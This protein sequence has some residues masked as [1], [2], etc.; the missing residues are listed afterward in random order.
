MSA[1]VNVSRQW[2]VACCLFAI[3]PGKVKQTNQ[4]SDRFASVQGPGA[5]E[6]LV[7]QPCIFSLLSVR[8][9][10]ALLCGK[11]LLLFFGEI[12]LEMPIGL[13]GPHSN[14]L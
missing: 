9:G 6:G 2:P 10:C 12:D 13:Q 7:S 8:A 14:E 3:Q 11:R 4:W 5:N 1:S